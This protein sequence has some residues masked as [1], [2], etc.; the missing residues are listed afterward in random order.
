MYKGII[1]AISGASI[2][3]VVVG[4]FL[5]TSLL[6]VIEVNEP[7]PNAEMVLQEY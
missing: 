6:V 3:A 2:A 7:I 4:H 1:G 5:V